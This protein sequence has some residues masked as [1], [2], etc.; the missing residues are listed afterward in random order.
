[1]TTVEDRLRDMGISLPSEMKLPPGVEVPFS[2]VRVRGTRAYVSGH[3]ALADD[4]SPAGPFGKVPSEV[5]LEAAQLSAREATL[6]ILA[7][8]EGALGDLDDVTAWL[9]VNGFVNADPGYPQTTAVLNPCSDLLLDLYGLDRG[10]HART[11]IGVAS[12]PLN[13]PVVISAEVEIRERR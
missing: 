5:P 3:G 10:R 8:L 7:S 4:G 11:A 6:A 9:V 13:L 2:W 1:V 12:V